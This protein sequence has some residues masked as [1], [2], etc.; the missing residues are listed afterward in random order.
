MKYIT[1]AAF[2]VSKVTVSIEEIRVLQWVFTAVDV[3]ES[4]SV[5]T[6]NRSVVVVN[7]VER[8]DTVSQVVVVQS[9]NLTLE[10]AL[11]W[12]EGARDAVLV[13][14]VVLADARGEKP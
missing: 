11:T 13:G 9:V 1:C 6:W 4:P 3:L 2:D 7:L 5:A 14:N 8:R 12:H 10:V